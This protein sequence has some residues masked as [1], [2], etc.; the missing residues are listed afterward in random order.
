MKGLVT[1]GGGF[2]GSN[3]VKALLA[4]GDTVRV[5]AR[6]DYPELRAL[7]AETVRGDITDAV[8]TAKACE[9]VDV[10]FHTAAKAGGWG[11]PKE[12]EAINVTGTQ[13]VVDGC[14]KAGVPH[15]VHT[16]SPSVVHAEGDLE[17]AN[18]SLPYAT[19]FLAHYPRTKALSEQL[20]RAASDASLKVVALRPHFIWGPGDRHLLPRLLAR[21]KAGRLRRIG[22]RDPKSDTIYIDNCVHAHLLAADQLCAGAAIGGKTYF[23]SDDEPIGVWTMAEKMLA[24]AGAGPITRSVPPG[25]AYAV[26]AMLEG[27]YWLFGIESEPLITRFAVSEL[28]HAQ[29]FDIGAAKRE[30]GYAPKVTIAEGLERLRASLSS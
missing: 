22:T 3:L 17:G 8:A 19:H 16:S 6:G 9:G 24:A 4:R 28:T 1:G 12:F 14:R 29:W 21:A 23:V 18:E 15:L 10:V 25:V 13:H 27:A 30:L 26:G 7:G 2:L 20:A 11:D 5:L